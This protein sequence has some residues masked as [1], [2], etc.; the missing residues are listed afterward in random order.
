MD[1]PDERLKTLLHQESNALVQA[2]LQL[3]L[4]HG[5]TDQTSSMR[6]AWAEAVERI[7]DSLLTWLAHARPHQ[8][9]GR[10]DY[11]ADPRFE[12][13]REI[14]WRH[15]EAG[16]P[17]ELHHGLFTLCR[18][19][20]RQHL[21]QVPQRQDADTL[22]A[23]LD[24]FFDEAAQAMLA[25]WAMR[26]P[27]ETALAENIRRLTRERDQYFGVLESLSGPV[28]ITTEEGRLQHANDA[29]LQSFL[30][31]SE[32]G[33]LRYRL[34]LQ[35]HRDTLQAVLNDILA[36][37]R[38]DLHAI[39]L[40][41][42]AGRRCFDIRLRPLEDS[43]SKLDRC[44]IILMNDVTGHQRAIERARQAEHTM[45]MF[46]AAMSH[47]IRG[48]LHSVLGAAELLRDA[49]LAEAE[50]LLDLLGLSAGALN[51]TLE[52][53]LSFSRF[54]HQAPQPRPTAVPLRKMLADLVR[55]QDVQARHQGVPLQ[56]QLP[57]ELPEQ[58]M[59]DG[60]LVQQVL[61]NLIRNAL[62][63]D[64]GQGVTLAVKIDG[65]ELVFIVTD[66][67]P[68]LPPGIQA[69]LTRP[70]SAAS[71]PLP[72]PVD[73]SHSSGLGLLIVRR[74]TQAL[75]GRLQLPA[76]A[77]GA[78][79]E[80]WLPLVLPEIT[81]LDADSPAHPPEAPLLDQSCLL[82]DNDPIGALGTMA[83]LERLVRSV[84]HATSLTQASALLQTQPDVYDFFIV[85]TRLPDG[86]GL[87]FARQ[88]RLDP[89]M[90][91]KPVLL[92]SANTEQVRQQPEA[93]MLFAAL[94]EKPLDATALAQAIR[95][96]AGPPPSSPNKEDTLSIANGLWL[97][98]PTRRL[99]IDGRV[100]TLSPAETRLLVCLAA[101]IG[102]PCDRTRISEAICG[103]DWVYGD[104]TVDVLVSRLRR[105]LRGSV[106]RIVT[107]HGL[108]YTLTV[109]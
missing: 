75:G 13:L 96:H 35:H 53:V 69:Q 72:D 98:T 78:S 10:N 22:L 58:V 60:S 50:S 36:A 64:D 4:A 94:L 40:D 86:S 48:P 7:N 37:G 26:P 77:N 101:A 97:D 108:G 73:N 107:V 102:K 44:L 109:G 2:I 28:F 90:A 79:I 32:A 12:R 8:L 55:T 59:L 103:R 25:P 45:S 62:R 41:T 24:D 42:H 67:G 47:E 93:G 11:R 23:V 27:G 99:H 52:N 70:A 105:R 80:V 61:G 46:L 38:H 68:G 74:M 95:R 18:Q 29:A 16:V 30:G 92:L 71:T 100:E 5:F 82:V 1:R 83:M 33:A 20:Y 51:A 31:L 57:A 104:R 15:Y 63:H 85:D 76:D 87:D 6:A 65:S 39:W 19:A 21:Q 88:I 91:G 17:L 43:A 3:A 106:A 81:A 49:S 14:A 54:R 66:H 84:D 34:A 56:L 89:R 9:D